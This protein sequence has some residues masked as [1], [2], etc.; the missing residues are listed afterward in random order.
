MP[1]VYRSDGLMVGWGK[2]LA[3]KQLSVEVWQI[4]IDGKK[5]KSLP[6]SEDEKIVVETVELETVPLVKAVASNDLKAVRALLANG[7]DANV[8][9]CVKSSDIPN[10]DQTFSSV[11]SSPSSSRYSRSSSIPNFFANSGSVVTR[12]A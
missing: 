6:G 8:K 10:Q 3:R 4:L 5:P 2:N 11:V 7:A 12:V 9:N 1:F